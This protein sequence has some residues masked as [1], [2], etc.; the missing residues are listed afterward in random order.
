MCDVF[1]MR[2]TF[3]S[4]RPPI[5]GGLERLLDRARQG[6]SEALSV[7]YHRF[8]PGIFGYIATR[9]PDRAMEEDLTSDVF[10][11]VVVHMRLI[12]RSWLYRW[13][14]GFR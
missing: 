2:P 11:Q 1:A 4:G 5:D 3:L 12:A 7:L 9:M 10:L 6:N 13:R 8:L 14:K